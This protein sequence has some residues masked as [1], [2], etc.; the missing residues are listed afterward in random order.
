[1]F[2]Y[3]IFYTLVTRLFQSPCLIL[4]LDIANFTYHKRSTGH[5]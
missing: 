4:A 1:M 3:C 5:G 2:D